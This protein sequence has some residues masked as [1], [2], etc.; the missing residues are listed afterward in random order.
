M[1]TII[2]RNDDI[3]EKTVLSELE[4]VHNALLKAG[5]VHTIA[6]ITKGMAKNK[7][8]VQFIKDHVSEFS[9]QVHCHSHEKPLTKLT[10]KQLEDDL[11]KA[12]NYVVKNF[13]VKPNTVYPPWNLTSALLV[14]VAGRLGLTV[15]SEKVSLSQY[16]RVAG[17]IGEDVINFHSWNKEE[18][19]LLVKALAI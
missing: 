8:V 7:E 9:I 19:G 11:E 16:I 12:V 5:K 18:R 15:S 1:K 3:G 17:D 10:E 4:E 13:G 14:E 6:L 2:W